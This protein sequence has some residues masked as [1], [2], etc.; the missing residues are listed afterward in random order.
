MS[1]RD[2]R[3]LRIEFDDGEMEKINGL[4]ERYGIKQ[5]TEL[6]RFIITKEYN[7]LKK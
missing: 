4:K 2:A 5:N 6:I 3:I 7:E 1:S